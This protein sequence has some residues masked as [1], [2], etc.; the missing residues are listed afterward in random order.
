[1]MPSEIPQS[2][3]CEIPP[4]WA[5]VRL[6]LPGL[7]LVVEQVCHGYWFIAIRTQTPV[8]DAVAWTATVVTPLL[9]EVAIFAVWAFVDCVVAASPWSRDRFD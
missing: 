2:W 5:V 1:M 7:R 6:A 3:L 9:G 8:A 4:P